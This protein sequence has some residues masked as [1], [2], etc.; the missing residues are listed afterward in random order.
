[1][2]SLILLSYNESV[3]VSNYKIDPSQ[4]EVIIVGNKMPVGESDLIYHPI[5]IA[6]TAYSMNQGITIAKGDFIVICGARSVIDQQYIDTCVKILKSKQNLGCVGG[7]IIHSANT[8]KGKAIAKSMGAPLGM[9]IMSF[10]SKKNSGLV[11]TVSVPV[12]Q[13]NL[14]SCIGF[15]DE[16]LIRN[17][18]DDMSYRIHQFG[19]DIWME[20]SVSSQYY[21]REK[22][23]QLGAQFFQYGFWKNYVNIKHQTLTT[24]RQ[25]APPLFILFIVGFLISDSLFG[26]SFFP[27]LVLTYTFIFGS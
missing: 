24:F 27:I 23:V 6:N 9:G 14:F 11:D 26:L 3:D 1:M 15:F 4:T 8:L 18:D 22:F 10:R 7:K 5:N 16:N 12:F 2:N 13:R 17:Q 19:L 25:L 20:Q 21:V